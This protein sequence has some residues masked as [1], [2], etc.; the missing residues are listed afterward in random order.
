MGKKGNS[1]PEVNK[2]LGELTYTRDLNHLFVAL[3]LIWK[4]TRTLS[5]SVC[6]SS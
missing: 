6:I 1:S 2:D 3:L 5:L 4:D